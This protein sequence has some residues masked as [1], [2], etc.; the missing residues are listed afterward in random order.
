MTGTGWPTSRM[1]TFECPFRQASGG[2]MG[3][4]RHSQH[5][6]LESRRSTHSVLWKLLMRI[7]RV[8][9]QPSWIDPESNRNPGRVD[10]AVRLQ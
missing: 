5:P 1:I 7:T 6:G 3:W 2:C 4:A 10:R 9:N 8:T